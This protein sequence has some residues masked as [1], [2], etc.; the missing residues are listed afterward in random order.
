MEVVDT[1]SATVQHIHPAPCIHTVKAVAN[2]PAKSASESGRKRDH[3]HRRTCSPRCEA[4]EQLSATSAMTMQEWQRHHTLVDHHHHHHQQHRH[5]NKAQCLSVGQ[6]VIGSGTPHVYQA[7]AS[8]LNAA[9]PR[10]V[11][12]LTSQGLDNV[13]ASKNGKGTTRWLITTT[14][15]SIAKL[16]QGTRHTAHHT[17]CAH[18]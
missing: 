12:K 9:W 11:S 17:A 10:V 13:W 7:A 15:T 18:C 14:T 1:N 6:Y 5:S 2:F 4:E 16:Q 3:T 8:L